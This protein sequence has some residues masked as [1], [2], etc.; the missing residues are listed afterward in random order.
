MRIH[1]LHRP[2]RIATSLRDMDPKTR[3]TVTGRNPS[4]NTMKIFQDR[5]PRRHI[6]NIPMDTLWQ[7][8]LHHALL[9]PRHQGL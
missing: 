5:V 9:R 6:I 2:L 3:T 4:H 1:R 7:G 8:H